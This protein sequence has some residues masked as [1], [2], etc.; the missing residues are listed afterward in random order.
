MGQ[1]IPVAE[2]A[3]MR[4]FEAVT[5]LKAVESAERSSSWVRAA[6]LRKRA[7]ILLHIISMGLRSGEYGGWKS[8][9][10]P[11]CRINPRTPRFF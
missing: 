2:V 8:T 7:L 3:G 11:V 5:L 9:C 6:A 4:L 10:E 1:W